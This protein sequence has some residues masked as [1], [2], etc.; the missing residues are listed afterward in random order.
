MHGLEPFDPN[1]P[2]PCGGQ[3]T[4]GYVLFYCVPDD[5]VAWDNA[6][7]MPQVYKQ[8]AIT[9]WLRCSPPSTA[10]QR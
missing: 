4:E 7:G 6:V 1:H 9:R 5:Y 10:W 2:P 8:G 3:S